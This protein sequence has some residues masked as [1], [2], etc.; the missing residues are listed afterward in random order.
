MVVRTDGIYATLCIAVALSFASHLTEFRTIK[1]KRTICLCYFWGDMKCCITLSRRQTC[2]T[3]LPSSLDMFSRF[4]CFYVHL[5]NVKYKRT[6]ALSLWH[7]QYIWWYQGG[8]SWVPETRCETRCQRGVS[9]SCLASHKN[10]IL[11]SNDAQV[12]IKF[13]FTA[14]IAILT[15]V[16]SIA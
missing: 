2:W 15:S 7:N 5:H 6:D 1:W 12:E 3:W 11:C 16:L 10:D 9:V 8:H 13:I 14:N 4:L